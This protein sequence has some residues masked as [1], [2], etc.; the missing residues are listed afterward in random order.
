MYY[1]LFD[2]VEKLAYLLCISN[3]VQEITSYSVLIVCYWLVME[4]LD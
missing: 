2:Y 4:V 1:S 3:I